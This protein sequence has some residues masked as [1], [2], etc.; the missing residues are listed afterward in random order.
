MALV[1]VTDL[2]SMWIKSSQ[3]IV[4]VPK[5]PTL[6]AQVQSVSE[7]ESQLCEIDLSEVDGLK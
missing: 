1:P 3:M 5:L 4:S 7:E 6:F 2:H